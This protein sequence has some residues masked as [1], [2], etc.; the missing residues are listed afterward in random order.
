M[1]FYGN[2]SASHTWYTQHRTCLRYERPRLFVCKYICQPT[3]FS[4]TSL[5]SVWISPHK[6]SSGGSGNRT[7]LLMFPFGSC[8]NRNHV[9][10]ET[11]CEGRVSYSHKFNICS[12]YSELSKC[13]PIRAI[14]GEGLEPPI[15]AY[16]T[17]VLPLHHPAISCRT[18]FSVAAWDLRFL[19]YRHLSIVK[20]LTILYVPLVS[21][22]LGSSGSRN[23]DPLLAK[24]VL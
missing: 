5:F 22:W 23:H 3:S 18:P 11:L 19:M 10:P 20:R 1:R 24:Q 12:Y 14:A 21:G 8:I 16:E 9:T 6:R 17:D 13:S 4:Y 2:V 7:H 15:S